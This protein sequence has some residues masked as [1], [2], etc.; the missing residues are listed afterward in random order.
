MIGLEEGGGREGGRGMSTMTIDAEASFLSRGL[1]Y[2][3]GRRVRVPPKR[4]RRTVHT[5]GEDE[6]G[7][8]A[9]QRAAAPSHP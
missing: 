4:D 5:A 3:Q 6:V 2:G 8:G 9:G 1:Y 7:H